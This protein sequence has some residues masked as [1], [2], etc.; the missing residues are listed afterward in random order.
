M[1]VV[2]GKPIIKTRKIKIKPIRA[3]VTFSTEE[4]IKAY[5]NDLRRPF[6]KYT[7][8]E[9]KLCR[10]VAGQFM[11]QTATP[12]G[13]NPRL[14]KFIGI[15]GYAMLESRL[16]RIENGLCNDGRK[17]LTGPP[18]NFPER[19]RKQKAVSKYKS[20]KR[21][22]QEAVR[23]FWRKKKAKEGGWIPIADFPHDPTA[24]YTPAY[25]HWKR[26]MTRGKSKR[27]ARRAV[28]TPGDRLVL[29]GAMLNSMHV[30]F[31]K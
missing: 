10:Q 11:A 27:R 13:I 31:L 25:E 5:H 28:Y 29:S 8:A 26:G 16:E 24:Q 9:L 7:R 12:K 2:G 19:G 22:D 15:L 21:R 3:R 17:L 4:A 20:K 14:R 18:Q 23:R 30:E 6:I 1:R